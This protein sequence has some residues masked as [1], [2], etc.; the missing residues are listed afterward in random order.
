MNKAFLIPVCLIA[1][2]CTTTQGALLSGNF[3]GAFAMMDGTGTF[4]QQPDGTRGF[5]YVIQSNAYEGMV[6]GN[7][8]NLRHEALGR[9]LGNNDACGNGYVIDKRTHHTQTIDAI[10]YEGHCK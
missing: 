3:G 6:E 8:E 5:R 4:I 10:I 9:W 1:T 7:A 2:A